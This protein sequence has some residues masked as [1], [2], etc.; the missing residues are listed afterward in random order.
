MYE[1]QI[2]AQVHEET[3]IVFCLFDLNCELLRL[4]NVWLTPPHPEYG[5]W[6]SI[7]DELKVDTLL[8]CQ[9]LINLFELESNKF[10][11][12]TLLLL[13]W[14]TLMFM[15]KFMSTHQSE[16]VECQKIANLALFFFCLQFILENVSQFQKVFIFSNPKIFK[17][18][19]APFYPTKGA[20]ILHYTPHCQNRSLLVTCIM[21]NYAKEQFWLREQHVYLDNRDYS[22]D[23]FIQWRIF[24]DSW[25]G[26]ILLFCQ[27]TAESG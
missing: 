10:F 3:Q 13:V 4:Q 6:K 7:M 9:M 21:Y 17:P 23:F 26:L 5:H 16:I 8:R 11:T 25:F 1:N 24:A 22:W 12:K 27:Q 15:V 2:I 19:C 18:Q 14:A 20:L